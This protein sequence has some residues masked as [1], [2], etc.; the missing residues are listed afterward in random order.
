MKLNGKQYDKFILN[1]KTYEKFYLNN[2]IYQSLDHGLILHL[3]LQNNFTDYSASGISMVAGN[4]NGFPS[5]VSDGSGGYAVDFNGT[6]SLKTAVNLPINTSDKVSIVFDIL[7]TLP[8]IQCVLELSPIA[9]T[10]NAFASFVSDQI[11]NRLELADKTPANTTFNLGNSNADVNTG[12]WVK[13]CLQIDR[14]L[15]TAQNKIYLNKVLSYTQDPAFIKDNNGNF[16]SYPLFIGGRN[17]TDFLMNAKFKNLK[18]YNYIISQ[19]QY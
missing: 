3:P 7:T 1:G 2:K 18:I 13:V 9:S 16:G 6:K 8:T 10:N 5:F 14:S 17:G 12:S 15:G 4:A 19:S 11:P